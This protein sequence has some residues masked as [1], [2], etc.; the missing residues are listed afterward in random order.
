MSQIFEKGDEE[1][2][3]REMSEEERQTVMKSMADNFDVQ[4]EPKV[5]IFW[6]DEKSDELFGVSKVN[7]DDLQFNSNGLKT[8]SALHKAWWQKQ[9]NRAVSKGKNPGIFGKDYTQI[10]WGRIFQRKDGVF[11]LR[12]GSWMNEHVVDLVKDE[13]DLCDVPF[14][15]IVSEHWEIGHGWNEDYEP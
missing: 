5:G 15:K 2:R 1:S 3:L 4:D 11:Q 7:A 14:E 6:Y 10:P 8:I 9:K 12:C 13:F